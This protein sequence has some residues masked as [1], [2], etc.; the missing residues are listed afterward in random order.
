[1]YCIPCFCSYYGRACQ[2]L[3]RLKASFNA[4]PEE[5]TDMDMD[6]AD[7][8]EEATEGDDMDTD[9]DDEDDDM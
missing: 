2:F 4:M 9:M 3:V 5:E 8:D 7:G 1:M 6:I